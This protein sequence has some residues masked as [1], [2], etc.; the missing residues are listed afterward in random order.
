MSIYKRINFAFSIIKSRLNAK[1]IRPYFVSFNITDKCNRS[2]IYCAG[3]YF[4]RGLSDPSLEEILE[5]INQLQK[6]GTLRVTLVGG[7]PLIRNDIGD[8]VS[9][10]KSRGLE[11]SIVSNGLL[12]PK[13]IDVVKN[14]EALVVSIDGGREYNDTYRGNGSY[15]AA[16]KAIEIAR[17]NNVKVFLSTTLY[18]QTV[19]DID[20]LVNIARRYNILASFGPLKV[21]Y[22][23]KSQHVLEWD[24]WGKGY[25]LNDKYKEVV[26]R[27][28]KYKD[29]N[30]PI[31]FSKDTYTK[32]F[33]WKGYTGGKQGGA[34]D[35]CWGGKYFICI[36]TNYDIYPCTALVGKVKS[37]PNARELGLERAIEE[38]YTNKRCNSCNQTCYINLNHIF[39]FGLKTFMDQIKQVKKY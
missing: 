27:I 28:L 19:D 37:P 15:Q 7:E 9:Y 12:V 35:R 4:A 1:V 23:I 25:F 32:S 16:V 34:K 20:E 8:I 31:F 39:D 17:S 26:N 6:L 2:C 33:N 22:D 3:Q 13:K 38:C 30:A 24:K 10:I 11:C 21:P 5:T 29:E 36:D 14:A 18:K